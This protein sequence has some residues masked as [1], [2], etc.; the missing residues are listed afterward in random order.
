M[1]TGRHYILRAFHGEKEVVVTS[2]AD[3]AGG[4][5]YPTVGQVI[6]GAWTVIKI[7]ESSKK[8][9]YRIA[10]APFEAEKS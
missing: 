4:N 9:E 3:V 8:G 6:D 10:V 5:S 2:V 1:T 7:L